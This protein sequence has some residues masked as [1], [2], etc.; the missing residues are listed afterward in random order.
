LVGRGPTRARPDRVVLLTAAG[1][2][3]P[4][5]PG[6]IRVVGSRAE[7]AGTGKCTGGGRARWLRGWWRSPPR[8]SLRR[9]ACDRGRPRCLG[10][11]HRVSSRRRSA[12][13]AYAS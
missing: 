12:H 9:W 7:V 1:D 8:L 11:G 6:D 10:R 5:E 3:H 4:A 13:T 2:Q